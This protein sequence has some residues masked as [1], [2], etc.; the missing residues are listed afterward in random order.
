MNRYALPS[1]LNILNT[2]AVKKKDF[3]L[4]W[5]ELFALCHILPSWESEENYVLL[6]KIAIIKHKIRGKEDSCPYACGK[7]KK[8]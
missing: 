8:E 7:R 6:R 3:L 4:G 2:V 1:N 5:E